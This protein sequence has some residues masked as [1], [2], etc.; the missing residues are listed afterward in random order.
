MTYGEAFAVQPFS[1]ILQTITLTG[2][3]LDSGAEKQRQRPPAGQVTSP[4]PLQIFEHRWATRSTP[5]APLGS[6]VSDVDGRPAPPCRPPA[7]TY[8]VT[9]NNFLVGRR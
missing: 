8:R 7:E 3:Q 4:F 6:R 2:D 1:N 5:G 9:V